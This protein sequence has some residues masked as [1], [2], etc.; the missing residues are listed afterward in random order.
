MKGQKEKREQVGTIAQRIRQMIG[1]LC[2]GAG[3]CAIFLV[4]TLFIFTRYTKVVNYAGIVRGGS[5]RVIKLVIANEDY[6]AA[7]EKVDSVID[8][9]QHGKNGVPKMGN[10]NFQ[11]SLSEVRTF[12]DGTIK[13]DIQEYEKSKDPTELIA[14]SE[15]YFNMTNDMVS[16]AE[17]TVS[18]AAILVYFVLA[19]SLCGMGVFAK[20]LVRIFRN[21]VARPLDAIKKDM[22]LLEQGNFT[23]EFVYDR[24]DE[25][26]DLYAHM[27]HTC[28]VLCSYVEDI[29]EN[30]DCMAQGDLV[31]ET[32]TEY[33]GDYVSIRENMRKIRKAFNEVM[34]SIHELADQVAVSASQVAEV[35]N[36]LAEGAVSQQDNIDELQQMIMKALEHTDE[37]E[38]YVERALGTSQNTVKCI[39]RSKHQMVDVIQAMDDINKA[40]ERIKSI[41]GTLNELTS[42]TSL[43]SLNASIEAAR[44]GEMGKG[45]AVVAEEVRKLA[46]QSA[47]STQNIQNLIGEAIAAIENGK[48]VVHLAA[49]SLNDIVDNTDDV[50]TAIRHL[51]DQSE[52]QKRQMQQVSELAVSVLDVVTNNSAVSQQCAS[53]S[54]EL[55]EYSDRLKEHVGQFRTK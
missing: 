6:S 46:D 12:W 23:N 53:S 7:M 8:G 54:A 19:V 34:K 11:N 41:L 10:G 2:F 47:E 25:I 28:Q 50:D 21:R 22:G 26:G 15:D 39:E 27:N 48:R 14:A 44:A 49:D 17:K 20:R 45:F 29:D 40:S 4:I 38:G 13:D 1:R 52:L 36:D 24:A 5:Q 3:I 42:Q 16:K 32:T 55:S 30:L 37:T 43:L 9:L 35:S 18:N 33:I 51:S 31:E